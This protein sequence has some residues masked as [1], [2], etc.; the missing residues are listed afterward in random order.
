MLT[1]ASCLQGRDKKGFRL[2]V[3]AHAVLSD[4]RRRERY[5]MGEDERGQNNPDMASMGDPLGITDTFTPMEDMFAVIHNR[6][7]I[8]GGG[9]GRNLPTRDD[10]KSILAFGVNCVPGHRRAFFLLV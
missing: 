1:L 9:G 3:E 6:D 10:A 4:P 5:D 7:G 2:V 8:F